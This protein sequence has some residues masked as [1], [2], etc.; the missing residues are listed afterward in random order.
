M[1]AVVLPRAL[2]AARTK[3]AIAGGTAPVWD[4]TVGNTLELEIEDH[5]GDGGGGGGGGGGGSAQQDSL[6]LEVWSELPAADALL[7]W[8]ALALGELDE[9]LEQE[10]SSAVRALWL[11]LFLPGMHPDRLTSTAANGPRSDVG[12]GENDRLAARA[13]AAA[14]GRAGGP[15]EGAA[16]ALFVEISYATADGARQPRRAAAGGGLGGKDKDGHGVVFGQLRS[17]AE[18]DKDRRRAR[19]RRRWGWGRG[20]NAGGNGEEGG[21]PGARA[22]RQ[23]ATAAT[24][25]AAAGGNAY[26]SKGMLRK[27]GAEAEAEARA[28]AA[29][30]VGGAAVVGSGGSGVLGM[31][32]LG[33]KAPAL[34]EQSAADFFATHTMV[35]VASRASGLKHVA[36]FGFTQAPYVQARLVGSESNAS[37]VGGGSGGGSFSVA[38]VMPLSMLSSAAGAVGLAS[39]SED[40]GAMSVARTK[41]ALQSGSGS[42]TDA[43]W[44]AAHANELSL[45][46]AQAARLLR[47]EVWHEATLTRDVLVGVAT[48]DLADA[49]RRRRRPRWYDLDTGGR[50]Q[51]TVCELQ[52]LHGLLSSLFF[53]L[54]WSLLAH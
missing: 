36:P 35:V 34:D 7:G 45:P 10:G 48:V 3:A 24:A 51:A 13:A 4:H 31:L 25:Q 41:A 15:D 5:T 33:K 46:M 26:D 1:R 40:P 39:S 52:Q 50:V 54:A 28:A 14:A 42:G 16:G 11:P 30:T 47:L 2:S 6:L 17:A 19:R 27:T 37:A 29:G 8:A 20:G 44:S 21:L 43:F 22:S 9:A 23:A 12:S 38:S 18:R 49:Q 53:L 32:G